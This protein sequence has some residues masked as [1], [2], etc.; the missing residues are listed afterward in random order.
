MFLI[1]L[2]LIQLNSLMGQSDAQFD[3]VY[4]ARDTIVETVEVIRYEYVYV[5][6]F[7]WFL[8]A[9]VSFVESSLASEWL[10]HSSDSFNFPLVLK[11]TKGRFFV[12]TGVEYNKLKFKSSRLE[13][14][15]TE[16]EKRLMETVVVDTIYR[17]NEGNPVASIITK[18][19]ERLYYETEYLEETVVSRHDYA[20]FFVPL[21]VGYS[22][23]LQNFSAEVGAGLGFNFL[24]SEGQGSLKNDF[25]DEQPVFLSYLGNVSLTYHLSDRFKL[26]GSVSGAWK[27]DDSALG[28]SQKRA[29]LKLFCKIF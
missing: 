2:F 8:G 18:E 23:R 9:G 19:V 10:D 22:Y 28:Y 16:V 12:Q 11:M 14:V 29:G 13:E 3:T 5:E 17:Y 15:A 26:Q 27:T 4:V 1:V 25:P 24:T 20:S 21:L 7:E 6:P